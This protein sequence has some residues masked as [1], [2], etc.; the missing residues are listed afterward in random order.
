MLTV[1]FGVPVYPSPASVSNREPSCS[2]AYDLTDPQ[3]PCS[4]NRPIDARVVFVHTD[5]G[6]HYVG[7]CFGYVRVKIDHHATQVPRGDADGRTGPLGAKFQDVA[8]P[9]IFLE[10]LSGL[11]VDHHIRPETTNIEVVPCLSTDA[12]DRPQSDHGNYGLIEDAVFEL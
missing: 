9:S 8:H 5:H 11:G 6:L 1:S 3:L 2:Q 4:D 12:P 7:V 10:W